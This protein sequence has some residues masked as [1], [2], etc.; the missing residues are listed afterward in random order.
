MLAV[1]ITLTP[2]Y[3]N[4]FSDS[5]KAKVQIA[6][7]PIRDVQTRWESPNRVF[8]QAYWLR[9]FS[10]EWP[11]NPEYSEYQQ[12]YTTQDKWTIVKYIMALLRPF[13]Y[14]MLRISKLHTV[15]LH[16]IIT[17]SKEMLDHIDGVMQAFAKNKTQSKEESFFAMKFVYQK[18]SIYY[19][20]VAPTTAMPHISAHISDPFQKLESFG[21]WDKGMDINP[22]YETL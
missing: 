22:E 10:S 2:G 13:W 21:K 19:T 15:T 5:P 7:L 12:L 4:K 6:I 16:H 18:L 11:K 17:V 3:R 20:A 14:W 8:E 9:E 1:L